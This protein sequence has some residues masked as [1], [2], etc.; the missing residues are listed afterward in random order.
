MGRRADA[1]FGCDQQA[2]RSARA[3]LTSTLISWGADDLAQ[4]ATL[5]LSELATNAVLH[6]QTPFRVAVSLEAS[7]LRVEVYDAS[8]AAPKLVPARWRPPM[9]AGCGW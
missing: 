1:D 9:G 2:V 7:E 3:F 8:T 4:A 5:C 6:A